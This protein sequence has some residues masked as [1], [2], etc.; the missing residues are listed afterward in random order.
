MN[1]EPGMLLMMHSIPKYAPFTAQL[2]EFILVIMDIYYP[3]NCDIIRRGIH[4]SLHIM[5]TKGVIP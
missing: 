1:I 4:N 5:L 2:L 3:A